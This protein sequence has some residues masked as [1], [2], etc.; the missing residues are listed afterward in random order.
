MRLLNFTTLELENPVYADIPPEAILSRASDDE[1]VTFD[2][3]RAKEY[4]Y[5]KN[6][7]SCKL[8]QKQGIEF[9]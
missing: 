4:C 7:Q 2:D 8:A 6:I 5:Q 3:V 9:V 1:E